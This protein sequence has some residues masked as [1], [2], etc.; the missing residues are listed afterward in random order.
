MYKDVTE[1]C[2]VLERAVEKMPGFQEKWIR[3]LYFQ[4]TESEYIKPYQ[5]V[6]VQMKASELKST[7][8]Y[9]NAWYDSC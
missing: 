3:Y 4:F 6:I 8:I 9:N 7:P 1:E 5:R 2:N